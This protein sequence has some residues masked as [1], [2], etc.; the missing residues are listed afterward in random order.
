MHSCSEHPPPAPSTLKAR[1]R[2][3]KSPVSSDRA[4]ADAGEKTN[5][6]PS[7]LPP[8]PGSSL[9]ALTEQKPRTKA[10]QLQQLWPHIKAALRE[11]HTL[12]EI[13]ERL[14]DDGLELS[15][16]K[17]RSYVARLKRM[18]AAGADLPK[19]KR[20]QEGFPAAPDSAKGLAVT[21]RDPLSNL[22]DHLNRKAGVSIRRTST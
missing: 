10:G 6:A 20:D 22:R 5:S 2:N 16:S 15:Y 12:L 9:A 21:R 4:A 14:V 11:G 18:E 8:P 1:M 17:L 19:I 13:R 7:R 3:S